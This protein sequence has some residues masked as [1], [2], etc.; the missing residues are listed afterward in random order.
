MTEQTSS[1]TQ[2]VQNQRQEINYQRQQPTHLCITIRW[3]GAPPAAA[4]AE[5]GGQPC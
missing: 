2:Q 5:A 4:D 3:R 1:S